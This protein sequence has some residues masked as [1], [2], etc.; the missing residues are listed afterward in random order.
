MKGLEISES[1]Q[2][3]MLVRPG[4][5]FGPQFKAMMQSCNA[6]E[7]GSLADGNSPESKKCVAYE[8]DSCWLMPDG[9]AP[10]DVLMVGN[11]PQAHKGEC[12][13]KAAERCCRE[14]KRQEEAVVPLQTATICQRWKKSL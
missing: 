13:H 10:A 11:V 2:T 5:A 3:S 12:E 8:D 4:A 6:V 1:N 7:A 14:H 9:C